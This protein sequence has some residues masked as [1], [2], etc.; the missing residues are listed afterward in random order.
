MYSND[1]KKKICAARQKGRSWNR[2]SSDFDIPKSSCRDIVKKIHLP[3]PLSHKSCLKVKGNVKKRLVLAVGELLK[4]NTRISSTTLLEKAHVNVSARTVQ[5]FLKNEGYKYMNSKKQIP[6]SDA[7]K[8]SRMEFCRKWLIE[9]AASK[10]I[11]FTDESRFKL[12]GPDHDMSWQQSHARRRHTKRQQGGGG[13]MIWGMLLPTG[14]LHYKEVKGTLNSKKYVELIKNF[15]LP[16][17]E[18]SMDGDW[19]WQQDNAKPHSSETTMSSLEEKGVEVL[20]WPAKSPDLNVIE[21]VWNVL[22]EF[23]Y[24][25]G[26]AKSLQD[27]R[28]KLDRAVHQFNNHPTHGMNIYGS[29][30]KRVFMCYESSGALVKV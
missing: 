29:F 17:I 15:A 20:G 30:G 11:V 8:A 1:L 19:L 4:S 3:R 9:G 10:N 2:I 18:A 6:L 28:A 27:L 12:D 7:H 23:I 16:I 13:I 26:A 22:G 5:R 21:N 25:D 24:R 14:V